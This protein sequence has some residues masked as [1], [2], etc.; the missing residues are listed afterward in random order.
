MSAI[1]SDPDV[2]ALALSHAVNG[3]PRGPY[4]VTIEPDA[5]Q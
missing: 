5:E 2:I 3:Q 1:A 4:L